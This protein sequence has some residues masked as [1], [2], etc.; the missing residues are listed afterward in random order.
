M[1]LLCEVL[2]NRLVISRFPSE[3]LL[4]S[5]EASPNEAKGP[6]SRLL[7]QSI[8]VQT[9]MTFENYAQLLVSLLGLLPFGKNIHSS[10]MFINKKINNS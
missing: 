5:N 3:A 7:V 1:R 9:C 4:Y 6:R 2:V 8:R 10:H